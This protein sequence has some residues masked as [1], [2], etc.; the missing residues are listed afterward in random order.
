MDCSRI[1][2][3]RI[4]ATL[5]CAKGGTGKRKKQ[6]EQQCGPWLNLQEF[7]QFEAKGLLSVWNSEV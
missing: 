1:A 5:L 2:A 7:P 3:K 6:R 4:G